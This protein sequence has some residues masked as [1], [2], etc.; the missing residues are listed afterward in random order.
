MDMQVWQSERLGYLESF[1]EEQLN[2]SSPSHISARLAES[3]AYSTLN[4]GKRIRALLVYAAGEAV[5]ERTTTLTPIAAALECIHAYSLIH[6]DL[7]AMDN[8]DLRRGKPTNHRAFDDATAIL[9]G[10][11]LQSLAFEMVL[12]N[13]PAL[14]AE[15][16]VN[17]LTTLSSAAGRDGMVGGQMLDMLATGRQVDQQQLA[18]IHA[19]K[20]GA[21][22]KAAVIC[23]GLCKADPDSTTIARLAVFSEKIGLAFQVVDDILDEVSDTKTLGKQAGADK[24]LQKSTYPNLIG[25]DASRDLAQNL[26]QEALES[27]ESISDNTEPLKYLA[28]RVVIRTN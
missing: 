24:A 23:G 2:R 5:G 15:K 3:M 13:S 21:L 28:K 6:D 14:S 16:K 7:P 8:D 27:I 9:A 19:A 26:L 11:A 4:T 20:T 12:R 18:G 1:L 25:L 22:I 17:I 10:D